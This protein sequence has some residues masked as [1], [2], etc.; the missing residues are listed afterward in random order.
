[1]AERP[2]KV[3][4]N[5]VAEDTAAV[6][7]GALDPEEASTAELFPESL[8]TSTDSALTAFEA[9]VRALSDPSD[10]DVML[11]V[12]RVVLALNEINDQHGGVGYET[13]EREQLCE[14]I[15]ASLAEAGI[16]VPA[17]AA[18]RGIGRWE[19]TDEWREW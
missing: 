13:G 8:L 3:W 17:L 15:D 14:Y 7:A 16:D 2:S 10:D 12:E 5:G 9:E 1:M 6:A 18:R 11:T 4:R 19:I